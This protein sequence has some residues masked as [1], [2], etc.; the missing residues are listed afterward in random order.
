M[1]LL[2]PAGAAA[3]ANGITAI[4]TFTA[5]HSASPGTTGASE[6][7]TS[8]RQSTAWAS[9]TSGS[10]NPSNTGTVSY[11]LPASTTTTH[12]GG[13]NQLATGGTFSVGFALGSSI[14]TGVSAG[15]VTA[16]PG[17]LTLTV[18]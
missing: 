16:A 17:G 5:L 12:V 14:T 18:T 1:S 3:A 13:W 11:P 6:I 7:T 10:P 8:T 9:A 15:T 2:S 4:T